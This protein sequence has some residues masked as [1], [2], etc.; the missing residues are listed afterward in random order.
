[1]STTS[2]RRLAI[3]LGVIVVLLAGICGWQFWKLT[4]LRVQLA[5]AVE[6]TQI[7]E[8]MRSKSL[9]TSDPAEAAGFLAYTVWYY[10]TGSKQDASSFL[11][12]IVERDRDAAIRDIIADLRIKTG[13]HLG[14]DPQ[15]WLEAYDP[16]FSNADNE[17]R[18]SEVR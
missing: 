4:W 3:S 17:L 16:H 13:Q 18:P 8:D 10:P 15:A 5:F 12:E 6:Q 1:M 14:G 7:F 11:D 2:Y 9:A